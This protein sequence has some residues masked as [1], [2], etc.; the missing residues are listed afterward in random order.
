[1]I[2]FKEVTFSEVV[3]V[4]NISEYVVFK[5]VSLVFPETVVSGAIE[6]SEFVTNE[7]VLLD[8][9]TVNEP[10]VSSELAAFED[11][12][13]SAFVV[14]VFTALVCCIVFVALTVVMTT[15]VV[16]VVIVV[17]VVVVVLVVVFVFVVVSEIRK[18]RISF[19]STCLHTSCRNFTFHVNNS[20]KLVN[21]HKCK[22]I[23]RLIGWAGRKSMA[24]VILYII[25]P[26]SVFVD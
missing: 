22:L 9:F 20:M 24:N 3:A 8:K 17:I 12:T 23:S 16:V 13:S 1:M 7:A 4:V 21:S 2:V 26:E 25:L 11:V 10:V 6:F 15:G 14:Y 18:G 5:S 19:M